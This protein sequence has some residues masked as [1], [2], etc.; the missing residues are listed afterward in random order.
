MFEVIFCFLMLVPTMLGIA[1]LIHMLKSSIIN[2]K[3]KIF[4]Y[5]VVVLE[6]ETAVSQLLYQIEK[7][8][9]QGNRYAQNIVAINSY[10]DEE[11]E[12]LCGEIAKKYG[13]CLCTFEE[14]SG[15]VKYFY[16]KGATVNWKKH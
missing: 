15:N 16:E 4:S 1:E 3:G 13:V 12:K 6:N 9:W 10:L 2:K 8:K 11:N 7:Y 14:I 5:I